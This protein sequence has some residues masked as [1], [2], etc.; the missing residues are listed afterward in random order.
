MCFLGV[1]CVFFSVWNR[2]KH[3]EKL[4]KDQKVKKMSSL[5]WSKGCL[6]L[7]IASTRILRWQPFKD[8]QPQKA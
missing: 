1:L 2:E 8:R 3:V 6:G 7:F 5:F 4:D